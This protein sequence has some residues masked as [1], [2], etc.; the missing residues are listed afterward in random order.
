MPGFQGKSN[1][2]GCESSS[3]DE[4]SF[5]GL[6]R[7]HVSKHPPMISG[8][9]I[10]L[11]GVGGTLGAGAHPAAL[12]QVDRRV[13][14]H[15]VAVLDAVAHFHVRSEVARDGYLP[16]ADRAVFDN[17]TLPPPPS[18]NNGASRA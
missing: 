2:L 3:A 13:E 17:R 4:K 6:S 9:H 1:R 8:R 10:R 15:L 18:H 16:D 5:P 12:R 11:T 14:D 7:P